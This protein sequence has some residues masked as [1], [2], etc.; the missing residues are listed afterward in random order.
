MGSRDAFIRGFSN[1]A[2]A[3]LRNA[4]LTLAET[5]SHEDSLERAR[6]LLRNDTRALGG[7]SAA[8]DALVVVQVRSGALEGGGT[9]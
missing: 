2:R 6:E 4:T 9:V 5:L 7:P 8:E 1:A 3:A